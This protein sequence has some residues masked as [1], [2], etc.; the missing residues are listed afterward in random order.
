MIPTR[1]QEMEV[2]RDTITSAL[3]GQFS[4]NA[5]DDRIYFTKRYNK[6]LLQ[7]GIKQVIVSKV[8]VANENIGMTDVLPISPDQRKEIVDATIDKYAALMGIKPDEVN[9]SSTTVQ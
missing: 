9:N 3:E 6:T 1:P 8:T 2:Y 4:W 5:Q 7:E